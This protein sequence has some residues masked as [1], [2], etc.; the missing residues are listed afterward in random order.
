MAVTHEVLQSAGTNLCLRSV[1]AMAYA[2]LVWLGAHGRFSDLTL[3]FNT[4]V[5]MQFFAAGA[6]LA[7]FLPRDGSRKWGVSRL[8]LGAFGL[9]CWAA[10][11]YFFGDTMTQLTPMWWTP[12][13]LYI[14]VLMGCIAL[15]LSFFG[16]PR[17]WL[18]RPLLWLGK[19]SYG[20]YVY[21]SLV[22]TLMPPL[23]AL[24]RHKATAFA[25][26]WSLELLLTILIAGIS[27]R[28]LEKPFLR[29]KER[30]TFVPNRL[31]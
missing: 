31:A 6:L 21:H 12:S 27:Y 8:I 18:P 4:L 25:A 20:L 10:G 17:Q 30:V 16:I 23:T 14:C 29:W 11:S 19:I 22:L 13:A 24:F 15:F 2:T 3:R 1:L 9:A 7:I 28:W 5:E 26:R